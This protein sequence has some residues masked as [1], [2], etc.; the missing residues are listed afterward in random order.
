MTVQLPILQRLGA[1]AIL[2]LMIA[3]VFMLLIF[4][5]ADHFSQMRAE[6][7]QNREALARFEAFS[8]NKDLAEQLTK[9]PETVIADN[10]FLDGE[11]G[12]LQQANLQTL[13]TAFA[14]QHGARLSSASAMASEN[15][16]GLNFVGLQTEF[17]ASLK[18]LQAIILSIEIHRPFLFIRSLQVTSAIGQRADEDLLKIRIG[19]LGVTG[20]AGDSTL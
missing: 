20:P 12:A 17:E 18:Q 14:E 19:V 6:I 4:P 9:R 15:I 5:A 10:A 2:I 8:K 13:M 7:S 3:T 11:T 1:L 16:E